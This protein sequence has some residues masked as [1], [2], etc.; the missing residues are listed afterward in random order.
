M[1]N[2]APTYISVTDAVASHA[3]WKGART[4]LVCGERRLS[5]AQLDQRVGRVANALRAAGLARGRKVALLMGNAPEFV[6][7]LLGTVRAGGVTVPLSPTLTPESVA[8]LVQD[9]GARH[10]VVGSGLEGLVTPVRGHLADVDVISVGQE[11]TF[12]SYEAWLAAAEDAE[13]GVTPDLT[14]D[15]NI[16]Y[17]SGTTGT[18]KG[19]VH[20][21]YARSMFAHMLALE[22]RFDTAAVAVLT[23]PL[24]SN[25]SW[26][27][28]LPA[29]T[30]GATVVV[31]EKFEP[32]A[33]LD[34]VAREG[35]THTFMVPPQYA[36]VLALPDFGAFDRSSLRL[37]VSAGAP[38]S[39]PLKAQI[40]ARFGPNLLE[41]YGLTEGIATTLKPEH[42]AAKLASVGTPT[43]GCDIRVV[44]DAGQEVP[45][46][47]IG[48]IVG[49]G[50]A[51][52]REYHGRPDATREA[53]WRDERGRAFLRTGDIGRLDPD[54]F[55]SILDRKKDMIVSG[56]LN[57][58]P[59]DLEAV[60]VTHPDVA[61]VAVIGVPHDKWGET[62]LA[63]VAL[64]AGAAS[65]EVT[66]LAWANERL[67]KHQRLHAVELRSSIPRLPPLGKI[68]KKELR[69]PYW[70]ARE[71]ARP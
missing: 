21:H 30:L 53:I 50:P 15:F 49:Y 37:L 69:A 4:A 5:W 46:G 13:L 2:F 65:D 48:E 39:A 14:D 71:E 45:R 57:V 42:V 27:L 67:A 29:L 52:M 62:P 32:R 20:T 16:I 36:A 38:L 64:R 25:G 8:L 31:M 43:F 23:T 54:G 66:L 10:L 24:S 12:K 3:K 60:L 68:P 56:G 41:L 22:F 44:D 70:A 1:D 61:D 47:E 11:P 26:M 19:I 7:V 6:E 35:G 51:L 58:Y 40:L 55:L 34:L 9:S 33:F 28:L 18:P 59:S 17:T 63:L